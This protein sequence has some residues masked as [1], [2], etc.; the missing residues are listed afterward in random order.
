M[1]LPTFSLQAYCTIHFALP[2]SAIFFLGFTIHVL[3][4]RSGLVHNDL[5]ILFS[6][7]VRTNISSQKYHIIIISSFRK[8]HSY[9]VYMHD[10]CTSTT[11]HHH[12]MSYSLELHRHQWFPYQEEEDDDDDD[13]FCLCL[14]FH[15]R[16]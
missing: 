4:C 7:N 10:L 8:D 13:E 16:W 14:C 5:F 3:S 1:L 15:H 9:S 12:H 6:L 11:I 2:S